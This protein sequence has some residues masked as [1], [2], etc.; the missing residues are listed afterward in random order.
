MK[1][2]FQKSKKLEQVRE[3]FIKKYEEYI[4]WDD[5]SWNKTFP[6]SEIFLK[7][8]QNKLNWYNLSNNES[9]EWSETLL[10]QFIDRIDWHCISS[11][12]GVTFNISL[13]D[14]YAERWS[15][16]ENIWK[17]ISPYINDVIIEEIVKI[18]NNESCRQ[19]NG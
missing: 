11:N 12:V 19:I 15:E 13:L 3:D 6:F 4:S 14:K 2:C 10:T 8:Y 18:T 1:I 17:C 5:F 9:I 7:D 16:S